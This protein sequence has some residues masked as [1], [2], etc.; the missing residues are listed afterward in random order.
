M[1][2]IFSND[3]LAEFS[4]HSTK[5]R[6]AS[7]A[8]REAVQLRAVVDDTADAMAV[9]IK[10]TLGVRQPN[11]RWQGC[12]N[13]RTLRTLL[14]MIDDRGFERYAL[15]FNSPTLLPC[16]AN[17]L[18]ALLRRELSLSVTELTFSV[19][20]CNPVPPTKWLS[21]PHSSGVPHV[22]S[23][24]KTGPPRDRRSCGTTHGPNARRR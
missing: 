9:D 4:S 20:V 5:M 13:L 18:A 23:T 22:S 6:E 24:S 8:R 7:R 3:I 16:L 19:V 1:A 14:S 21:T 15:L 10:D 17:P 2:H 11:D 12:V